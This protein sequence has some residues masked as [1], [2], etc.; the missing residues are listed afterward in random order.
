M[1]LTEPK[2]RQPRMNTLESTAAK[3]GFEIEHIKMT[4]CVL[5]PNAITGLPGGELTKYSFYQ[6]NGVQLL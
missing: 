6:G 5:W 3:H 4:V 2:K 1:A